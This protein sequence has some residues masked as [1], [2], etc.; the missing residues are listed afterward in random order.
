MSKMRKKLACTLRGLSQYP[1]W[2]LSQL[3][4]QK[5]AGLQVSSL[6]GP[7]FLLQA[8]SRM[9]VSF[10][11]RFVY[12]DG[13]WTGNSIEWIPE[14]IMVVFFVWWF[15]LQHRWCLDLE[16]QAAALPQWRL[17]GQRRGR[18]SLL[19]P[20]CHQIQLRCQWWPGFQNWTT[21]RHFRPGMFYPQI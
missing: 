8:V 16:G 18:F 17:L 19:V 15:L 20:S 9:N 3:S 5:W 13:S 2:S 1:L 6:E 21:A 7:Y 11:F 14:W 10:R 12:R 4:P